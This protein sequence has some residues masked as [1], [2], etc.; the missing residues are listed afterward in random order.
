MNS[1]ERVDLL[2][3]DGT[4]ISLDPERP[5]SRGSVAVRDGRIV[6]LGPTAEVEAQTR[7]ARTLDAEHHL[8]LPGLIDLHDHLRNLTPGLSVGEGLKLDEFLRVW[9][10]LLESQGPEEYH[11]IMLLSCLRLL[12]AGVTAVADH[13]YTFHAP[14]LEEAALAAYAESGIRWFYARGIM[15]QP[16]APICESQAVA[17]DRIRALAA[18]PELHG[19]LAIAPVSL[20]QAP[21]EVYAASRRLA[22]ELG[23]RLYTHI[24][25][26]PQEVESCQRDFGKRPIELLHS[27]GWTGPDVTLVHCVYLS[28]AEVELLAETG[29]HVVHCPS[30]H[31]KLA[32]G[33]TPVPSYL[34]RGINVALGI[35][36][37][38]DLFTEMRNELLMQGLATLNPA[39]LKPEQALAMATV[40]GARAL[41]WGDEL[42]RIAVGYRADLTLVDTRRLHQAPLVDPIYDLVFSVQASDVTDVVVGGRVVVEAGRLVGIDEDA[43]RERAQRV[44]YDYLK[45]V[46]KAE[47]AP[48]LRLQAAAV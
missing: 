39:V 21:P 30:N 46:G 26:T 14:G 12:K 22:D 6:A 43:V 1:V 35:D 16:Y 31:M 18:R 11:A 4:I 8:V 27:L 40:N 32:K 47:L 2:V 42:G 41:G 24:A 13:C 23:V 37:M 48:A 17:F 20:R 3:R 25:E 5:L 19:R 10:G 9:W 45:R 29:T 36:Q 34:A 38:H 7:P 44:M 15:T 28:A 33:V